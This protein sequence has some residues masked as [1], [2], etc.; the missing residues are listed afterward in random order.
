MRKERTL[1]EMKEKRQDEEEQKR[2]ERNG[3]QPSY[4][5]PLTLLVDGK[6]LG[7]AVD[8]ANAIGLDGDVG[9]HEG[10]FLQQVLHPKQMLTVV[11]GQQQHLQGGGGEGISQPIKS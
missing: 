5:S 7:V 9:L 2:R 10:V 4:P 11:L 3:E 6:L 1:G 8:V